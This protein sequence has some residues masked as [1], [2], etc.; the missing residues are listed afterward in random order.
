MYLDR[1]R[2]HVRTPQRASAPVEREIVR[3]TTKLDP[4]PAQADPRPSTQPSQLIRFVDLAGG[5]T[6]GI[7]VAVR[8]PNEAIEAHTDENGEIALEGT[9]ARDIKVAVLDEAWHVVEGTVAVGASPATPSTV[10]VYRNLRIDGRIEVIDADPP[11]LTT[12]KV[13][14][15]IGA[16]PGE[17]G[18]G[19]DAVHQLYRDGLA[20]AGKLAS[21]SESGEFSGTMPRLKGFV[22]NASA[23]GRYAESVPIAVVPGME[24]VEVVLKLR[25]GIPV[26]GRLLDDAG[27]PVPAGTLVHV[28][29]TVRGTPDTLNVDEAF[30][31]RGSAHCGMTFRLS[32]QRNESFATFHYA[33][34]TNEAGEYSIVLQQQGDVTVRAHVVGHAPAGASSGWLPAQGHHI[35]IVAKRDVAPTSVKILINGFPQ[36]NTPVKIVELISRKPQMSVDSR[37][38]ANGQLPASWLVH[39]STYIL[40]VG[41]L[42][43][44]AVNRA[45]VEWRGQSSVNVIPSGKDG[46]QGLPKD[47]CCCGA[48]LDCSKLS[49]GESVSVSLSLP[50]TQIDRDSDRCGV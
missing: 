9:G 15:S 45:Y 18:L 2:D 11:D 38:D 21:P 35:D 3:D 33:A 7:P 28:Y 37:T 27:N 26:R 14:Y 19:M 44:G 32:E 43:A 40:M 16:A 48:G 17:A 30:R 23:P 41:V 47:W 20:P 12:V 10:R 42:P 50:K 5:E 1:V 6:S 49:S 13:G 24:R 8:G 22:V 46:H 36:I 25:R 29:V 4:G 39:G 31:L 34:K